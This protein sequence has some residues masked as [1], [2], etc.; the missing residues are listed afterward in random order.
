MNVN[1]FLL[2]VAVIAVLVAGYEVYSNYNLMTEV[3]TLKASIRQL[4]SRQPASL[5]YPNM[6]LQNITQ[7]T[8]SIVA[9]SS[10]NGGVLAN[11]TLRII[12]GS[13][14]ALVNTDP[15]VEPDLQ[16]SVTKAVL[17]AQSITNYGNIS[18]FIFTY[19]GKGFDLIGGESAGAATAILTIAAIQDKPLKSNTLITGTIEPDGSVGEVSGI[20]EKAQVAADS[21]YSFFLV[22]NGQAEITYFEK[23]ITTATTPFGIE[24]QRTVYVPHSIDLKEFAKD[25]WNLTIVEVSNINQAL[26]Y[27]I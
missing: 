20:L 14:N 25:H 27:F 10:E 22:P 4:Y 15:F 9:V 7:K 1:F 21:N 13:N 19:G 23:N 16:F 26:P 5:A 24:I 17:V 11:L 12:P 6:T 18:D 3:S 8:I 2:A